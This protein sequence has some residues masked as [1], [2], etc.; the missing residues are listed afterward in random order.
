[1]NEKEA[2]DLI[3]RLNDKFGFFRPL[4]RLVN[5][6]AYLT[7]PLTWLENE[8]AV[9]PVVVGG[10]YQFDKN[11]LREKLDLYQTLIKQKHMDSNGFILTNECDSMLFSS[12]LHR[13]KLSKSYP[14]IMAA[15]DR[16]YMAHRRP[17]KYPPCCPNDSSSTFSRDMATG[18]LW[19]FALD[20]YGYKFRN[21]SVLLAFKWYEALK[22]NDFIMGHGNITRLYM[23][24]GLQA[25][26]AE[27]I[28]E[29][30]LKRKF[31]Q[32][33]PT[34]LKGYE[35]HLNVLH[36][37]IRGRLLGGISHRML[38]VLKRATQDGPNNALFQ[39]AYAK[40]TNGDYYKAF[41]TLSLESLFPS[42][43][44]P[45]TGDRQEGWLWQRDDGDDWKPDLIGQEVEHTGG[46]F[47]FVA[48]LILESI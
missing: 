16:N 45:T 23:G 12:L 13:T 42:H 15:F 4:C 22:K 26:L 47:I 19:A 28:A 9:K 48:S 10:L 33:W 7:V 40:Y 35:L 14:W 41:A 27:I 34:N 29:K 8:T 2:S 1:M 6:L 31:F 39:Y 3:N 24:P 17:L 30:T 18:V 36:I 32:I 20:A 46:D 11:V 38:K 5:N 25:T 21:R 37:L 44:L 43:R